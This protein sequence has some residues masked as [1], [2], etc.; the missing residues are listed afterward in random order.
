MRRIRRPETSRW[1]RHYP[2][3]THGECRHFDPIYPH[4]G[5]PGHCK[6]GVMPLG[7]LFWSTTETACLDFDAKTGAMSQPILT[8]RF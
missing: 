5:G 3:P 7:L 4:G 8:W 6:I 1:C 2:L